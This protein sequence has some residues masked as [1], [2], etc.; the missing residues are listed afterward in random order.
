MEQNYEKFE[1][2]A[3]LRFCF[4]PSLETVHRMVISVKSQFQ[5]F[6][7][8]AYLSFLSNHFAYLKKLYFSCKHL[9]VFYFKMLVEKNQ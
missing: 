2:P 3:L 8:L 7:T 1:L 9:L 4:R 6:P 5:E